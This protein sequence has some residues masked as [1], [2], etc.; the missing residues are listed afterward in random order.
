MSDE[1]LSTKR[2]ARRLGV[3]VTT[4]YDW[5]G[6]SDRNLFVLHGRVVTIAYFQSGARGQ[7]KIL[8][9]GAE[10]DR[11]RELMRSHPK[12]TLRRRLPLAATSFPGVNVPLGRP[13]AL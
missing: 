1:L 4:L 7:G 3:S 12:N 9:E 11:L 6:R 13:P 2:A 8:L 10:I 5:L